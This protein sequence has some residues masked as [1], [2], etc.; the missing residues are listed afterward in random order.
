MDCHSAHFDIRCLYKLSEGYGRSEAFEGR[1]R[2]RQQKIALIEAM[3]KD[4]LEIEWTSLAPKKIEMKMHL[5][6]IV[7]YQ[8]YNSVI[9]LGNES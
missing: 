8:E 9:Q 2:R 3:R 4:T 6:V 1:Y 7:V 5:V